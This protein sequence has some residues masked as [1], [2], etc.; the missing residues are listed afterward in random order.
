[1]L[2]NN[3]SLALVCPVVVVPVIAGNLGVT[4]LP[5]VIILSS[6]A[7]LLITL[8][9]LL[10]IDVVVN[11][12]L[13]VTGPN[14]G[15][16][17][18]IV[19]PTILDTVLLGAILLPNTFCPTTILALLTTVIALEPNVMELATS[20]VLARLK[21]IVLPTMLVTVAP[22]AIFAPVTYIPTTMPVGDETVTVLLPFVPVEGVDTLAGDILVTELIPNMSL[23][24]LLMIATISFADK[25]VLADVNANADCI[26]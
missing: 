5:V 7:I 17:K 23:P 8:A 15:L 22:L 6:E 12:A 26:V 9:L 19:L 18:I 4:R 3:K 1:M 10:A 21:K 13:P 16:F 25:F 11:V 24:R 2:F 20:S 14:V